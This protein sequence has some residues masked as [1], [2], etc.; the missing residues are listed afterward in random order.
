MLGV[1][2]SAVR[3]SMESPILGL[4]TFYVMRTLNGYFMQQWQTRVLAV[5]GFESMPVDS[6]SLTH[7]GPYF[8]WGKFGT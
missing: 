4:L 7:T 2:L 6:T 5:Q 8:M 3:S 1:G